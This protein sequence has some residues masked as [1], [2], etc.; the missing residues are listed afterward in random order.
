MHAEETAG[1]P[2]TQPVHTQLGPYRLVQQLG[3][4]G[5]GVVHL[6]L[7]PKGRAVAVKVLRPHIAHDPDA[8]A[9]LAREVE[10]LE[11]VQDP[12]VAPVIDADIEGERPY[13][14]T[15]Y[16]PG[17]SL[18]E[19]IREDGP[20]SGEELHRLGLGL[21]N[22]LH[23]IHAADVI[24]R[25]LKPG[26]VLMLDGEPVLIDF[27][28]A[29]VADDVRITM[30]GLVMGTP[31]YLAPE[32]VEGAP[33]TEATD[34]WG[35]AATL[36]FAASG[37][38]PF[39]RGPMD[40]VL[41]RVSKGE[42]DLDGVDPALAPLLLAALSP[43]PEERPHEQAVISGLERY[44][45]GEP[46][47][48]V[49]PKQVHRSAATQAV[50]APAAETQA[51]APPDS[52]TQVIPAISSTQAM[53]AVPLAQTAAIPT[54]RPEREQWNPWPEP[55][56]GGYAASAPA[57]RQA[58]PREAQQPAGYGGAS[59]PAYAPIEPRPAAPRAYSGSPYG[60]PEAARP[61]RGQS[62]GAQPYAGQSYL[63]QPAPAGYGRGGQAL[64]ER[65][66]GDLA[67]G[68]GGPG[69]PGATAY[70]GPGGPG[71]TAPHADPRI[72]RSKRT[73]SL[74]ALL[75]GLT[76]LAA[77]LPVVALAVALV[78]MV[79]AKTVDNS[80]T[81][82][83][84]RRHTHGYRRSDVPVA[85]LA[86]P[87]HLFV[88][89]VGSLASLILPV[90]VGVSGAICTAVG[91][92]GVTGGSPRVEH[93]VPFAV[94]AFLALLMAWWG[95]GGAS[96][97][98]GTRSI[99]RGLTPGTTLAGLLVMLCLLGAGFVAAYQYAGGFHLNW[100]P[101]ADSPLSS[102]PGLLP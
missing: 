15:R 100:W 79:L 52:A 86:S 34:W 37:R 19:V 39:G 87:W 7:D 89:L 28:I 31:G 11:R 21:A 65:P 6:G 99:V 62:H 10:T 55:S 22:A 58:P 92:A 97:R 56:T 69:G 43:V 27:G 91:L 12:G 81:S 73:G 96:L 40:V 70:P 47:T 26:N 93:A 61:Y 42:A 84:M 17:P 8:R 85:M 88:A 54:V 29:H 74:A 46:V 38:P 75:L 63:G 53:P 44:A 64:A 90:L 72:S 102:L 33:V 18:D 78:G 25:D 57:A 76:A 101:L 16:V 24:H 5:M 48:D 4:G 2:A 95:P 36:A 3:E 32:V 67:R 77:I 59:A 51:V 35:W 20:M 30:T 68:P 94:G 1:G 41:N 45:R 14:V 23:A 50:P 60:Q 80:V 71:A 83:V 9:R 82:T 98:R 66:D 13:I 49:L